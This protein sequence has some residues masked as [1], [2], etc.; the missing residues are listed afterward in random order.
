MEIHHEVQEKIIQLQ[1][2]NSVMKLHRDQNTTFSWNRRAFTEKNCRNS[3]AIMSTDKE[4]AI[5]C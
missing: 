4:K 2:Q 1:N 3:D 5:M